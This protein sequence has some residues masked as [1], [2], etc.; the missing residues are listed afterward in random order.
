[1]NTRPRCTAFH[2]AGHVLAFWWNAQRIRRV[3]VR[4]RAEAL[5]GPMADLRGN[6]LQVKGLVEAEYFVA[7]PAFE[8]SG[9]A[10][11]LPS[12]IDAIERDLL[13]CFSGP[14]AEAIYRH[15]PST[16]FLTRSGAGDRQRAMELISLLP[17]RKVLDAEP[18]AIARSICLVRRYWPALSTVA[19]YLHAQGTVNG[20]EISALLS[21]L[22]GE[23]PTRQANPLSSLDSRRCRP[24]DA[25][26]T[27]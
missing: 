2:E 20:D 22:T 9:I 27:G 23:T 1:M 16:R 25:C 14:V 8:P 10:E 6:L 7:L 12:M 24:V 26:L 19:Q 11:Y 4:T 13:H 5:I 15:C 18:K 3:T 21:T 17:A